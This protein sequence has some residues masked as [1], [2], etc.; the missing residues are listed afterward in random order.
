MGV[1]YNFLCKYRRDTNSRSIYFYTDDHTRWKMSEKWRAAK[2]SQLGFHQRITF[3]KLKNYLSHYDIQIEIFSSQHKAHS[4]IRRFRRAKAVRTSFTTSLSNLQKLGYKRSSTK[5]I[6]GFDIQEDVLT[7]VFRYKVTIRK[8]FVLLRIPHLDNWMIFSD[9][10]RCLFNSGAFA[11]DY[12]ECEDDIIGIHKCILA[13]R[14]SIFN[15]WYNVERIL[16]DIQP[17]TSLL[18]DELTKDMLRQTLN[19]VYGGIFGP[20]TLKRTL[21][22]LKAAYLLGIQHLKHVCRCI[23]GEII[24]PQ[25]AATILISALAQNDV[26]LKFMA[27]IYIAQCLKFVIEMDPMWEYVEMHLPEVR[28]EIMMLREAILNVQNTNMRDLP[29]IRNNIPIQGKNFLRVSNS[30]TVL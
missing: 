9:Q 3:K 12:L 24:N 16:P 2:S 10:M 21:F 27:T 15:E 8:A 14:S 28:E 25:T 18:M 23:I 6:D 4:V 7:D 26:N 20:V 17:D 5:N 11:D 13:S 29:M 30:R 1:C 22:L 19:F